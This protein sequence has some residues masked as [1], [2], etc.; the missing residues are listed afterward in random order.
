MVSTQEKILPI[1]EC[2]V[3]KHL[4]IHAAKQPV[5]VQHLVSEGVVA[6]YVVVGGGEVAEAAGLQHRPV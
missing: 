2:D 3:G 6:V 4:G 5:Y 1:P